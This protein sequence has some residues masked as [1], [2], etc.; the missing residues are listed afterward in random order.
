M[1]LYAEDTGIAW[2]VRLSS[3]GSDVALV[4]GSGISYSD[5][6][7]ASRSRMVSREYVYVATLSEVCTLYAV[8]VP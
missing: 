2:K 5:G 7:R 8:G 4:G 3:K 1:L 6:F